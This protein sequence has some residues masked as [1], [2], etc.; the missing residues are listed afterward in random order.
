MF[1]AITET[2]TDSNGKLKQLERV[3][4]EQHLGLTGLVDEQTAASLGQVLGVHEIVVGKITDILHVPERTWSKKIA[5]TGTI[6]VES[7]N[8]PST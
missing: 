4:E 1:P 2:Y 8:A 3:M 5:Q 6:R 7:G